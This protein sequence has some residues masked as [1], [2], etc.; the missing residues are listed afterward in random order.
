MRQPD[1]SRPRAA[2]PARLRSRVSAL[3]ALVAVAA[4]ALSGCSLL[5]GSAQGGSDG[6][7]SGG[8]SASASASADGM[9]AIQASPAKDLASDPATD[10]AYARYYDQKLDWTTCEDYEDAECATLTVPK[11]WNDPSKGDVHLAMLRVRATD[12]S[13]ASLLMNPGGPGGSGVDFVGASGTSVVSESVRK[14]YDLV[15]FDPRGV[16]ASDGITCLDDKQTDEYLA[17]TFDMETAEGLAEGTDWLTRIASAC[18]E[19]SGDMLGYMDTYSAARDMDVMR[20]AVGSD[21]L[22]YLGFSY[23]TY[24]GATYA[25]LYPARTGRFVLDGALDPSLNGDQMT[26]GQ[27]E[28]FEKAAHAFGDWCV[29]QAST[30]CPFDGSGDDAVEALQKF[31]ADVDAEPLPTSD[32]DRPLTGSLARQA[33]LLGMYEDGYWTYLARALKLAVD[34]QDG[35]QL[36]ALADAANERDVDGHYSGNSTYA[37]TAVNCLDHPAHEDDAWMKQNSAELAKKYP[38]FGADMGYTG[39]SCKLWPVGPM[40]SPAPIHA[41]GSDLIVVI[42]TTGDPATPYAWAESLDSQLDNSALIT[43]NGNGHTAYGRS[44]GCVEDA[45]D[46]Y[47]LAGTVPAE[48]LTCE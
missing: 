5:D 15:G 43:F 20:A 46:Q 47:L 7:T 2:S 17:S 26:A 39:L 28:G 16:G 8:P 38:T 30:M 22:D 18:K 40:R 36:L 37:I 14:N 13:K 11:A 24:L 21:K 48:G 23:G 29:E 25:D 44:G 42:G 45:V 1:P 32:D 3:T 34:D 10:S 31:F 33:V 35:T 9:P 4:L 41:Q 6:G 27:A 19:H 12:S